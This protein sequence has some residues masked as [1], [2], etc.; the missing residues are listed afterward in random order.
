MHYKLPLI[1]D[2]QPE[3]GSTVTSPSLPELITEGDMVEDALDNVRDA[4]LAVLEIYQEEGRVLPPN[5]A[6][7]DEGIV[8][9]ETLVA[10]S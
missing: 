9:A 3:G 4:L 8:W 1:F 6:V 10:V 2:P 5:L 7:S